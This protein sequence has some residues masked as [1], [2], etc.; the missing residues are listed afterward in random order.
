MA[1]FNSAMPSTYSVESFNRLLDR[2]RSLEDEISRLY[3]NADGARKEIGKLNFEL[4][5][6]KRENADLIE[7][8]AVAE[9]YGKAKREEQKILESRIAELEY[10]IKLKDPMFR[11]GVSIRA[12]YLETAKKAIPSSGR[13]K[14]DFRHIEEGNEAAH[15]A[16]GEVDVLLFQGDII[17]ESTKTQLAAPFTELYKASPKEYGSLSKKMKQ[18]NDCEA[19]IRTINVINGTYR[20][21]TQ[22][23]QALDQI[24]ILRDKYSRLSKTDFEVDEDVSSRL[25]RLLALTKEIVGKD[26][27][28]S[29]DPL[30]GGRR[31]RGMYPITRHFYRRHSGCRAYF[32]VF[33]CLLT[34]AKS[35]LSRGTFKYAAGQITWSG[36][37]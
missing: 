19:T 37:I 34:Q 29:Q 35:S 3:H 17:S 16:M 5:E 20:P 27:Q 26:R 14:L 32:V 4:R 21:I 36:E 9:V 13:V 25:A 22:R 33:R 30:G 7:D 18:V 31:Q 23:Q 24:D 8:L 12:R 15:H 2:C 10:D 1:S 11:V 6:C 28:N